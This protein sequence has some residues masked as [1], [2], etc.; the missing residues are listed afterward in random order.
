MNDE[1]FRIHIEFLASIRDA[2]RADYG[3]LRIIQIMLGIII[4]L[5]VVYMF[6]TGIIT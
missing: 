1:Q 4:T 5:M 6:K 3:D 2:A